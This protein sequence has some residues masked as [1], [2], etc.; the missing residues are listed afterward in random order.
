MTVLFV[1]SEFADFAKAGGLADVA[2]ALP[3]A[4]RQRG[5]DIRLLLPA[6][7]EV[8]AAGLEIRVVASLPGRGAIQP[9]LLGEMMTPDGLTIYLVLAPALYQRPGTPY[10][11]PDGTDWPDN[12]LRF[13][14]L[15]LAAAE[16]ARGLP[17][18]GWRPRLVHCNDWPAALTPAYM[19]WAKAPARSVM[20]VHNL[21][22][23]GLFDAAHLAELAIPPEAF[24][25]EGVEFHG[26]ISFLKAGL[27]YADHVTTVSPTYA[28]EMATPEFGNGLDGLV[29]HL[30]GQ[31]R[32]TGIIN[33]IG[34]EWDPA[35]D[36]Y[37]LETFDADRLAVKRRLGERLRT[38]LCL[39]AGSGPLF[40]ITSRLVQQKGIDLVAD[41]AEAIIA[42]GGQIAILGTGEPAIE[43]ML[44]R[45]VRQHRGDIGL[46]TGYNEAM[47]HRVIAA[48]DFYLMPSRFEP[49]G[50]TQM[51]ALRYGTLPIA[52]RTGG[53]A[54][55]IDDNETGF[56]FAPFNHE[57][58]MDAVGRA[59]AAFGDEVR[60]TRMRRSAMARHFDWEGPATAYEALYHGLIGVSPRVIAINPVEARRRRAVQG[61]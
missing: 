42:R 39:R 24:G 51:Q 28:R 43:S 59:F 53:L 8:I 38:S 31:G 33:G 21:A 12:H 40:G 6:Y 41:C 11:T 19:A 36:P 10:L 58:F 56:L 13:A 32:V 23:Q 1:A 5:V 15:S 20:T 3:R 26:R 50:L 2:A 49:C 47:A 4:L 25:I 55:T 30:A 27:Y 9:C 18:L 46:M 16:I 44:L 14:R 57:A 61:A 60:L 54:D 7:P 35:H 22:H 37:L 29:A 34:P 17:G 48:S 52:H 45:L